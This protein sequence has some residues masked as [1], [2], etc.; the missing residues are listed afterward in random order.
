MQRYTRTDLC[1][2]F[3]VI[4]RRLNFICRHF[5]TLCLFHHHRQ[6]FCTYLPIK[7]EQSAPK[8]RHKKFRR[9]EITQK[10]TCN[11][12]NTAKV[13][14]QE[15]IDVI[16]RFF[17]NISSIKFYGNPS[18]DS[19]FDTC[20]QMGGLTDGETWRSQYALFST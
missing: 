1:A 15:N 2:F 20:G 19:R 12:Q 3:W 7:M 6:S 8:R 4:P 11:I 14:N 17:I 13:L 18:S 9:R 16:S 5:G 10:K